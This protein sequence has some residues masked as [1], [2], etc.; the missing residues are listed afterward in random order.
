MEVTELG[1]VIEVNPVLAKAL[2]PILVTLS[3]IV[4]EVTLT[5][6]EINSEGIIVTPLPIVT[7]SRVKK[8]AKEAVGQFVELYTNEVKLVPFCSY[9][10][11]Y[12]DG[13]KTSYSF[14]L[15]VAGRTFS[16]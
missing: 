8:F 3:G 1:I 11:G 15:S 13:A 12:F 10:F 5:Q 6:P 4:K 2:E 9:A 7:E 16:E 14:F